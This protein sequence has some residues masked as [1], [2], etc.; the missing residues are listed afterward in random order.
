MNEHEGS[1]L[2]TTANDSGW[3]TPWMTWFLIFG[4]VLVFLGQVLAGVGGGKQ[5]LINLGVFWAPGFEAGQHWRLLTS[6]FLHASPLHL[7]FNCYILYWLGHYLEFYFGRARLL[8]CYLLLAIAA[9]IPYALLLTRQGSHGGINWVLEQSLGASGALF[10]LAGFLLLQG[11]GNNPAMSLAF[12]RMVRQGILPVIVINLFLGWTVPQINNT[13]HI[14]G[15]AAGLILGVF[16]RFLP[17]FRAWFAQASSATWL[18]GGLSAVLLSWTAIGFIGEIP[19]SKRYEEAVQN[20]Y[21]GFNKLSS[22]DYDAAEPYLTHAMEV[23]PEFQHG[24]FQLGWCRLLP[25]LDSDESSRL[26]ADSAAD[27]FGIYLSHPLDP[28]DPLQPQ[29]LLLAEAVVQ[30]N[31]GD[32][33]GMKQKMERLE[34]MNWLGATSLMVAML[35]DSGASAEALIILEKHLSEMD[36]ADT[37]KPIQERALYLNALSWFL[38]NSKDSDL[39]DVPRALDLALQ[40]VELSSR[41]EFLHTLALAHFRNGDIERA[42]QVTRTAIKL[43]PED[44]DRYERQLAIFLKAQAE[45]AA[46]LDPVGSG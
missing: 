45:R 7:G 39:H 16:P 33:A 44:R 4:N 40:A 23:L 26:D 2:S 41:P 1:F 35:D 43:N 46:T 36:Q 31:A 3:F 11:L 9:N 12:H 24:W 32:L 6:A 5:N 17:G 27:A 13:V 37:E 29:H 8:F 21:L 25:I 34:S 20:I 14:S 18:C 19:Q 28:S 38:L 30:W 22:L 10:G 15:L 42:I